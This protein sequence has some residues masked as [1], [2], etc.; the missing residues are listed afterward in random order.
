M[1]RETRSNEPRRTDEP[2]REREVIVT[3]RDRS[4]GIGSVIAAIIG[5]IVV[6]LIAWFLFAG[7]G[8]GEGDTAELNVDAPEEVTVDG[9]GGGDSGGGDTGG[10]G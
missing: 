1:A 6:G 10:E 2:V 9:D 7:F 3:D 8:G 4:S 5:I